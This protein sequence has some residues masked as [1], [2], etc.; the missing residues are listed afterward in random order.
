MKFVNWER[1]YYVIISSNNTDNDNYN[2]TDSR[3]NPKVLEKQFLYQGFLV[4]G[5]LLGYT[6]L[7]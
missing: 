6:L 2:N 7:H 1:K 3:V 5:C 4:A